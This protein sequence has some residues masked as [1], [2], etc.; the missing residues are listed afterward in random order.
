MEIKHYEFQQHGDNRGHLVAVENNI[1]IPFDIKRIYYLY[2]TVPGFVRG[3]HSHR[4]LEQVLV[5]V[6][7][8][9]TIHL[10]DGNEQKDV[11]LNNPVKGLYIGPNTWRE[12]YNFSEDA[13]L[14]VIASELY[15]ESDYIRNYD[16][17]LESIRS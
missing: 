8:S 16:D 7:G 1:D 12:I 11:L 3:K 9:C 6:A 13:V 4:K 5:C 14:L 17:F 10:D 15:D 2:D